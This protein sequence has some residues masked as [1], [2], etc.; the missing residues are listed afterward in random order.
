[1]AYALQY[2][3]SRDAE[4]APQPPPQQL[5]NQAALEYR[6][7]NLTFHNFPGAPLVI[8]FHESAADLDEPSWQI[9]ADRLVERHG[10]GVL[11][12]RTE[13]HDLKPSEVAA[14]IWDFLLNYSADNQQS[15]NESSGGEGGPP[16]HDGPPRGPFILVAYSHGGTFA[17][18]FIQRELQFKQEQQEK[19]L[20]RVAGLVLIETSQNGFIHPDLD[21]QQIRTKI[22]GQRPV[23]VMRGNY[24]RRA[25]WELEAEQ[26]SY[27]VGGIRLAERPRKSLARILKRVR[28]EE[29]EDERL[30][31]RQ[32]G[33]SKNNRIVQLFNCGFQVIRDAPNDVLEAVQWVM[34]NTEDKKKA[35]TLWEKVV[36]KVKSFKP[37]Q[38]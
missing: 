10:C 5:V 37:W 20:D 29:A 23:C 14:Q 33:L 32:L 30:T 6:H 28:K 18:E 36:E 8:F 2:V 35:T 26:R 15:K 27:G 11:T 1:M 31:V 17:R 24:L 22:M 34:D 19:R 13:R 7:G 12:W 4:I 25:V 9:L 38:R 21:K 3:K 16:K